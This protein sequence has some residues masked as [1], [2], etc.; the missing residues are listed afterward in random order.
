VPKAAPA[1]AGA[2]LLPFLPGATDRVAG[3]F[4]AVLS[5]TPDLVLVAKVPVVTGALLAVAE[6]TLVV[7]ALWPEETAVDCPVLAPAAPTWVFPAVGEFEEADV[8]PLIEVV[9]ELLCPFAVAGVFA[10]VF[11]AVPGAVFGAFVDGGFFVAEVFAVLAGAP[12]ELAA[13]TPPAV[14]LAVLAAFGDAFV[15]ADVFAPAA[16][17]PLLAGDAAGVGDGLAVLLDG[18]GMF[19]AAAVAV[20]ADA[21]ARI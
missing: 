14:V 6:P 21:S 15:A 10:A 13:L 20:T 19:C 3:V 4:A 8:L 17:V 18:A 16:A 7:V 1:A 11:V 12:V 5:A 2:P 9:A